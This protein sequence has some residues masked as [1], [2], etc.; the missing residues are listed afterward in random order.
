MQKILFFSS[1]VFFFSCQNPLKNNLDKKAS[2]LES[3]H[4]S[5]PNNS[6]VLTEGQ[7]QF[8]S[9]WLNKQSGSVISFLT[10]CPGITLS[11]S[12]LEVLATPLLPHGK[13]EKKS[14]MDIPY[15]NMPVRFQHTKNETVYFGQVVILKEN[16]CYYSLQY[17]AP[18]ELAYKKDLE[19]FLNFVQ[20][21]KP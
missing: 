2:A 17:T 21:F 19:V 18:S 15:E 8:D 1:L 14:P 11:L 10:Y 7:D 16:S 4:C 5:P 20:D 13:I 6:Y 9:F 3:L 12:Q